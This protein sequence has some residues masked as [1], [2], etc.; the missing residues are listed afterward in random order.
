MNDDFLAKCRKL[1]PS[2]GIDF[3]KN[4]AVI[5]ARLEKEKYIMQRP[6]SLKKMVVI[7]AVL[8]GILS[9]S[10][11]VYAAAP[12]IWRNLDTRVIEGEEFVNEVWVAEIDLPDGTTSMGSHIDI[13]RE[14]LEAAGGGAV[15]VEVDGEEWVVLDEL[16]MDN[17]ED[18]LAL[19]ELENP[20]LPSFI[21]EG[22]VFDRFTFPVDPSRHQYRMGTIPAAEHAAIYFTNGDNTIRLQLLQMQYRPGAKVI[23]G[24]TDCQQALFINGHKALIPIGAL[25]DEQVA[26]IEGVERYDSSTNWEGFTTSV[27]VSE[28]PNI[29][30]ASEN[31]AIL[32]FIADGVGYTIRGENVSLYDLVRMA[33]S[34]K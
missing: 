17:M 33:S 9:L 26:G 15:I 21:P 18:G 27:Y 2:I 14:A 5:K 31:V 24:T 12:G 8:A 7:A 23:M 4:R 22:F 13:D 29:P 20:M 30:G 11:A 3:E 34:M 25:T 10:V 28:N 6:R 32:A 1:D 16:T 19:L